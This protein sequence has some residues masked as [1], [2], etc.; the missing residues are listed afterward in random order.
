M[1]TIRLLS[2]LPVL[3]FARVLNAQWV[4]TNGPDGGDVVSFAVSGTNLLAGTQY[5]GVALS[6]DDGR[7][8]TAV[9][10]TPT[11][12]PALILQHSGVEN[13]TAVFRGPVILAKIPS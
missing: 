6:T 10:T 8:W 7:S 3:L 5:G 2:F 12:S 4:E 1:H 9:N 11:N 13:H